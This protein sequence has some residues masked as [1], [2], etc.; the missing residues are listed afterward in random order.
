MC[1]SFTYIGAKA[2]LDL[3]NLT[4]AISYV[5][6]ENLSLTHTCEE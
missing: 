2:S 5:Y 3:Y 4:T 1:E 6:S